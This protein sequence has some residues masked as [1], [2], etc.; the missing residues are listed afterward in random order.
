MQLV[1]TEQK[2]LV[3][4]AAVESILCGVLSRALGMWWLEIR[5]SLGGGQSPED[6][7]QLCS[8]N[9]SSLTL[10]LPLKVFSESS[11]YAGHRAN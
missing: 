6:A 9:S 2:L 4:R 7:L 10:W 5:M 3:A 1:C 11:V 8:V